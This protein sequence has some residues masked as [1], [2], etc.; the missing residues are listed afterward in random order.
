VAAVRADYNAK[1]FTF[2]STVAA[3]TH[4]IQHN[5]NAEFVDPSI[6]VLRP[7]GRY[8]N[9][10]VSVEEVDFNTLKVYASSAIHVKA[11]VVSM[12]TL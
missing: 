5:L 7:D 6:M 4:I 3:T 2:R 12:D 9:D 10:V 8:R 1:R 11:S